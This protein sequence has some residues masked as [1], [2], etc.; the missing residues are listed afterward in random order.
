VFCAKET[1]NLAQYLLIMSRRIRANVSMSH[2]DTCIWNRQDLHGVGFVSRF[3]KR[4]VYH[5]KRST[6]GDEMG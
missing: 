4:A 5:M 1:R 3:Y 6:G 2:V